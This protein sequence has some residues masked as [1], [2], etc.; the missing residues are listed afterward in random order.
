MKEFIEE[1]G[2]LVFTMLLGFGFF[3]ALY[4]IFEAVL[5]GWA[6]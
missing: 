2:G 3:L 1:Y 5:N 6:V 4:K